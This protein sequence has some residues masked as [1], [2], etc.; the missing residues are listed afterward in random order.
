MRKCTLM[1]RFCSIIPVRFP[2]VKVAFKNRS[3]SA[4]ATVKFCWID[5]STMK[6]SILQQAGAINSLFHLWGVCHHCLCRSILAS[7]LGLYCIQYFNPVWIVL[8]LTWLTNLNYSRTSNTCSLFSP[9]AHNPLPSQF[10][11]IFIRYK[12]SLIV[13]CV[14]CCV[15]LFA[16]CSQGRGRYT[17]PMQHP[18]PVNLGKS[19]FSG[20]GKAKTL[21]LEHL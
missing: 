18:F 8:L 19:V 17:L 4:Y 5:V 6:L 12:H 13:C 14:L 16:T 9:L 21:M 3:S 15:T 1:E 7:W 11:Y 20:S 2:V 10:I